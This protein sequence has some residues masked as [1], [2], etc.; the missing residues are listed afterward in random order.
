MSKR[1][2]SFPSETKVKRGTRIVHGDVELMEKLGR[3]DLCPCG[4]GFKRCCLRSKRYDG[5][6]RAHYFQGPRLRFSRAPNHVLAAMRMRKAAVNWPSGTTSR[7]P[8]PLISAFVGAVIGSSAMKS[9]PSG[10]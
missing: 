10:A 1:R 7:K 6:L 4:A 5:A 2:R 3:N 8:S 9:L